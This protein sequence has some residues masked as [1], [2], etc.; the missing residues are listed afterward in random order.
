MFKS[1]SS[2][3]EEAIL[4]WQNLQF[5][6][7]GWLYSTYFHIIIGIAGWYTLE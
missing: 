3:G 1:L 6:V 7:S 4:G 5:I 2:G